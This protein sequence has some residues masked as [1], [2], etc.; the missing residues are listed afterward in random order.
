MVMHQT[1]VYKLQG[2]VIVSFFA[3]MKLF[4]IMMLYTKCLYTSFRAI[5][6]DRSLCS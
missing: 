1:F 4:L 5:L 3:F 2:D 6:V